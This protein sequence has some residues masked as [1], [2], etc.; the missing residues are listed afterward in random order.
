MKFPIDPKTTTQTHTLDY[1][2][3]FRGSQHLK[4]KFLCCRHDLA[5]VTVTVNQ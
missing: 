4:I 1:V 3:L 2:K 5:A